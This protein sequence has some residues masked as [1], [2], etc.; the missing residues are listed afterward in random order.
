MAAL[1]LGN[2][3]FVASPGVSPI[4]LANGVV[5]EFLTGPYIYSAHMNLWSLHVYI[6]TRT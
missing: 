5:M 6:S 4:H 3:N 2:N 1:R